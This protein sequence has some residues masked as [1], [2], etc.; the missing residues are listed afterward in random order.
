MVDELPLV[1]E[2]VK[3]L[4]RAGTQVDTWVLTSINDPEV[5]VRSVTNDHE[6]IETSL[7]ELN[8]GGGGDLEEQVL[9]GDKISFKTF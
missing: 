6:D 7:N 9:R 3:S 4:V 5:R 2:M 8:Y 1:R